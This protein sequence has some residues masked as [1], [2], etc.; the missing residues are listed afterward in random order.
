MALCPSKRP[1]SSL[2]A[3]ITASIP[4]DGVGPVI[5]GA[6]LPG[7]VALAGAAALAGTVG[8][9]AA[10]SADVLASADIP[11]SAVM[12]DFM[13]IQAVAVTAVGIITKV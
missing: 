9:V 6:A 7:G 1:N 3:G 4:M 10:V 12:V 13:A 11:A 8:V 2:V 5:T